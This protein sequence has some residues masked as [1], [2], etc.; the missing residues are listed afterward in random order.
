MYRKKAIDE[1][2]IWP[3]TLLAK[4]NI[5]PELKYLFDSFGQDILDRI[6]AEYIYI[7][8]DKHFAKVFINTLII[9]M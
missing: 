7:S 4:E 8:N 3:N 6:A 2:G 1:K 5:D 9:I